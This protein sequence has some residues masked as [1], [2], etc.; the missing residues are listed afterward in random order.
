MP[1]RSNTGVPFGN[2]IYDNPEFF[3]GSDASGFSGDVATLEPQHDFS[4][5]VVEGHLDV[6]AFSMADSQLGHADG[7]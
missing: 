7:L 2:V 6:K 5:S 1:W 3:E 4:G